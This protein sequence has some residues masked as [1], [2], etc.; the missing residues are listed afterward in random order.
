MHCLVVIPVSRAARSESVELEE[1]ATG[2]GHCATRACRVGRV[3]EI[4]VI[5]GQFGVSPTSLRRRIRPLVEPLDRP[6]SRPWIEPVETAVRSG[7]G[8]LLGVCSVVAAGGAVVAAHVLVGGV[9]GVLDLVGVLVAGDLVGRRRSAVDDLVGDL[10]ALV[11]L[12]ELLGLAGDVL[13]SSASEQ[14]Y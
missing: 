3:A 8:L 1:S 4:R 10:L 13:T 14:A 12:E 6:R 5:P 11:A 2:K 9:A 7:R